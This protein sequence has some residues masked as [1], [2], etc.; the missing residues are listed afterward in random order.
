MCAFAAL[1]VLALATA[2]QACSAY[3]CVAMG[4]A[5]IGRS[6]AAPVVVPEVST[7]WKETLSRLRPLFVIAAVGL[8]VYYAVVYLRRKR[9]QRLAAAPVGAH[10]LWSLHLSYLNPADRS[11]YHAYRSLRPLS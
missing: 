1:P 11:R 4:C 7:V 10:L 6:G 3:H 8:L 9:A 2:P 5:G